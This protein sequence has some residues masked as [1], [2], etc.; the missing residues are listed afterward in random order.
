MEKDDPNKTIS[1]RIDI[2]NRNIATIFDCYIPSHSNRI[3]ELRGRIDEVTSNMKINLEAITEN[4]KKELKQ[5][6][7]GDFTPTLVGFAWIAAGTIMSA[8]G[9]LLP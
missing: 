6:H 9:S 4:N 7:V 3:E 8:I 2:A 5:L 1:D